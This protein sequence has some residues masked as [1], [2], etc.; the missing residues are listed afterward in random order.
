M[1]FTSFP[2]TVGDGSDFIISQISYFVNIRKN[3]KSEI[4]AL[5]RYRIFFQ[6]LSYICNV[7]NL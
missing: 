7:K 1:V 6:M 4:H 3:N 2:I 5:N